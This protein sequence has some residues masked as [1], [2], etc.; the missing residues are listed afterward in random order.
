MLQLSEGATKH[1]IRLRAERGVDPAA[2]ARFV[3]SGT[4]VGLAFAPSPE[5]G[6]QVIEGE[7]ISIYVAPQLAGKLDEAMIDVS[8]KD[9]RTGLV[10]RRKAGA[11]KAGASKAG[12]EKARAKKA[13]AK[14]PS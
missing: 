6:D 11:S 13:P 4:G 8:A 2:G 5:S 12:A 10:L 9:G 7:E 1:L 14:K 3:P